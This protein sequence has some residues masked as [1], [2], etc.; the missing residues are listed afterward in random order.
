[1]KETNTHASCSIG[2]K[3]IDCE[4]AMDLLE[5]QNLSDEEQKKVNDFHEYCTHCTVSGEIFESIMNKNTID[6]YPYLLEN[7]CLTPMQMMSMTD[8]HKLN[9]LT[10]PLV[11][12]ILIKM[13]QHH[14]ASSNKVIC[15]KVVQK[16]YEN[17]DVQDANKSPLVLYPDLC[18]AIQKNRFCTESMLEQLGIKKPVIA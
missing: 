14:L 3:L 13:I 10:Y 2:W 9:I 11:P 5:K 18:D 6:S 1:M 16:L 17:T 4:N 8:N 12:K 7:P 15:E